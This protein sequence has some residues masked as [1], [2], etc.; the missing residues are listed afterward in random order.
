[1][2]F[3]WSD[4]GGYLLLLG[5]PIAVGFVLGLL[6][7]CACPGDCPAPQHDPPRPSDCSG[8]FPFDPRCI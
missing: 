7:A 1:M 6:V 5:P 4:L 2:R 8:P 3:F